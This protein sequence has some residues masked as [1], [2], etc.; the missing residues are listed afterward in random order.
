M[1][2]QPVTRFDLF[3]SE[4]RGDLRGEEEKLKKKDQ[5]KRELE[6]TV[7]V[8]RRELNR[9]E[10]ARKDASIK[11]MRGGGQQLHCRCVNG[12]PATRLVSQASSLELQKSQL[13]TKLKQK[14]DELNKHSSMIAMIHSLSSGKMKNDVN[15]SL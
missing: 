5:E 12:E 3:L 1:Q 4:L 10:Q 6:E 7:D 13:E 8:L 11:V 2:P 15:L 14:E 9:T